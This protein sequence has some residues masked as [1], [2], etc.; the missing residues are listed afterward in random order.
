MREADLQQ[1]QQ[2]LQLLEMKEKS[3]SRSDAKPFQNAMPGDRMLTRK[4][5][6]FDEKADDMDAYLHRFEGYAVAHSWPLNK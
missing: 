2:E 4:L 5:P 3:V 1:R 6:A